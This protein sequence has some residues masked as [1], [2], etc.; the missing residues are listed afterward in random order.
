MA[1]GANMSSRPTK[2][3]GDLS[4]KYLNQK[5]IASIKKA[6]RAKNRG[7]VELNLLMCDLEEKYDFSIEAGDNVELPKGLITYARIDNPIEPMDTE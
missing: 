3:D 7:Q 5:D 6:L 2:K 1:L 4:V